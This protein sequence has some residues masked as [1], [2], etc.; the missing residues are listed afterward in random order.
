MEGVQDDILSFSW[1]GVE[2]GFNTNEGF[3]V[4]NQSEICLKALRMVHDHMRAKETA[5]HSIKIHKD[6]R[7]SVG[8]ARKRAAEIAL[9]RKDNKVVSERELKRKIVSEEIQDVQAKKRFLTSAIELLRKDADE[10]ALEAGEKKDFMVLQRSN[11][12]FN[13]ANQKCE[14]IIELDK[15]EADLIVRKEAVV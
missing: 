8:L 1:T 7:K 11:D 14:Q 4:E 12:L 2:R 15:I 5:P 6:L 3:S 13:S 9:T 10:L